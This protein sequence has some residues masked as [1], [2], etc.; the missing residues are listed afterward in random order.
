MS[1]SV[2]FLAFPPGSGGNHLRNMLLASTDFFCNTAGN[3]EEK[4]SSPSI[5]V[6]CNDTGSNIRSENLTSIKLKTA[7][8]APEKNYLFYGHFAELLSFRDKIQQFQNKKFICISVKSDNCKRLLNQRKQAIGTPELD[9]YHVGEQTFLYE[10]LIYQKI[11]DVPA[12][13]VMDISITEFFSL[14]LTSVKELLEN[15]LSID[16]NINK[17]YNLHQAWLEKNRLLTTN[18]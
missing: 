15:F 14:D 18:I 8:D 13:C 7:I 11:Y 3:I 12:D 5:T 6:H 17:M 10:S 16:L 1:R 4:Y 9:A 2:V